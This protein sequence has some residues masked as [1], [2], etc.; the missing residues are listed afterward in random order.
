MEKVFLAVGY[1]TTSAVF[2]P[3]RRP[4]VDNN[5]ARLFSLFS[6]IVSSYRRVLGQ[7]AVC[8][9]LFCFWGEEGKWCQTI[10]C[11]SVM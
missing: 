3:Q 2:G 6:L 7:Q 8:L 4:R 9:C 11:V 1:A 5:L 10:K